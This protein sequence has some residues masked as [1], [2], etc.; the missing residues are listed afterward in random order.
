MSAVKTPEDA[1]VR[2][3]CLDI[4]QSFVVTA[5]AGSGKTSLLTQRA[6][7]LLAVAK[8]PEEVLCITFTR[9]AAAEMRARIL[10]AL[11]ECH[12]LNDDTPSYQ[13]Q[14]WRLAQAVIEQDKKHHWQL[15]ENPGRLK[16]T[17]IDG[18]CRSIT[19]Q[20]PLEARLGA[21]L[22][23]V[24]YPETVYRE[25]AKEALLWLERSNSPYQQPLSELINSLDGDTLKLENLLCQLL[26]KRDQWLN[27]LLHARNQR[28]AL[29]DNTRTLI[30]DQLGITQEKLWQHASD[31][32]VI[33]DF[34]GSQLIASNSDSV[35]TELA[36][37]VDLPEADEDHLLQWR[38]ITE[39]LLTQKGEWRKRFDKNMG[40]PAGKDPI[41][42]ER[43]AGLK[44]IID[45]LQQIPELTELLQRVRNLPGAEFS[46][47]QWQFLDNLTQVLP[48]VV[49]HLKILFGQQGAVDFV[50]VAQAS[51]DALSPDSDG[52]YSD[53][54]LKLDYRLQH[55]LVDE[56]QDTS[57]VQW[58]LLK[59]LTNEWQNGD[60]KTLFFVG[61][62][63]Q[64]CYGFRGA[65]VSLFLE[66]R[67]HGLAHLPLSAQ[68]LT[69]NFRSSAEIVGWVNET[70]T[71]AFPAQDDISRGAVSYNQATAFYEPTLD[72]VAPVYQA[73]HCYAHAIDSEE[74][75]NQLPQAKTVVDLVSQLK[76]EKPDDNI[77]I[78]VRSRSHL[79]EI[80]R[81]L[82]K[83]GFKGQATEIEALKQRM[84]VTDLI[85]LT[86]ALLIPDDNLAWF[87]L[88]R[89]PWCALSPQDLL[90]IRASLEEHALTSVLSLLLDEQITESIA[91]AESAKAKLNLIAKVIRNR[92]QLRR[93][94]TLRH[95]VESTW[96]ALGGGENCIEAS[97]LDNAETYW[98]L[99]EKFDQGGLISDWQGFEL[100]IE[101]LYAN[102]AKDADPNLQIMTI[103]KSKGLEFDHVIIP[104]LDK[105]PKSDDKELLLW[106]NS[107]SIDGDELLLMAPLPEVGLSGFDSPTG[108]S[109]D[110]GANTLYDYLRSEAKAKNYFESVRLLYVGCTRA[111]KSLHLL[112][113][114]KLTEAGE[115]KSPGAS[116]VLAA[117]WP[118]FSK[119]CQLIAPSL[120]ESSNQSTEQVQDSIQWHKIL[121]S[122]RTEPFLFAKNTLLKASRGHEYSDEINLPEPLNFDVAAQQA[123]GT[124]THKMLE[125]FANTG[126][127]HWSIEKLE[128][129]REFIK[130]EFMQA[131]IYGIEANLLTARVVALCEKVLNSKIGVWILSNHKDAASEFSL[132]DCDS[133]R[134]YVIDR[135]FID[136]QDEHGE[137]RWIIDYKTASASADANIEEFIAYE[138]NLY[139]EQLNQYKRLFSAI[140][141]T[142]IKVALYFP[143]LDLLQEI[144]E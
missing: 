24:E 60:G 44:A 115:M 59:Q 132:M 99:L 80:Q 92:W 9:K 74:T 139:A 121:R 61:D 19:Q 104:S 69:T 102:T 96:I 100:G 75:N 136:E 29:E 124:V 109:N 50:E 118:V 53:T 35:I 70:F 34:C 22:N 65:D 137:V 105:T 17:T 108:E 123:F 101:H 73:V 1:Q 36:G 116:S 12:R 91:L 87:S 58:Q 48:L 11:H 33:A 98:Q 135:T 113:N 20:L 42:V 144:S 47:R 32:A 120:I 95:W 25:A 66:A 82:L 49:G 97:D 56:F 93:R 110:S 43:K 45:E 107:V 130:R 23:T 21:E 30:R 85:S 140:D 13:A 4:S 89:A 71:R 37:C 126:I 125:M 14:T 88:L 46:Q 76:K 57:H 3:A 7:A 84:V 79:A 2:N 78:L 26:S 64:S 38:A 5:P 122:T 18:F 138:V 133:N 77:A 55:I 119:Q 114:I 134:S 72:S 28:E 129:K 131:A 27:L 68:A 63:M 8:T 39:L 62:G 52:T 106:S 41:N 81:H 31:L 67:R 103:H 128:Q 142:P 127:T 143:S 83:A 54:L 15:L 111:I 51:L 10:G 6:L 141:P 90:S 94:S 86:R 112:A 16:I 40:L 117:I